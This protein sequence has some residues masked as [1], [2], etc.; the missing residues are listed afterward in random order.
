MFSEFLTLFTKRTVDDVTQ[1]C[2]VKDGVNLRRFGKLEFNDEEIFVTDAFNSEGAYLAVVELDC[3]MSSVEIFSIK[4]DLIIDETS[5]A[6]ATVDIGVRF[7]IGLSDR[8]LI[9]EVFGEFFHFLNEVLDI[10]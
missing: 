7:V 2:G 8:H 3:G 10:D 1:K 5:R 4:P 9:A 6:R